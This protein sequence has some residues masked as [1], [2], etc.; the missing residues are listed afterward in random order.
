MLAGKPWKLDS[1]VRLFF[2]LII[3]LCAGAVA[4][5]WW[6]LTEAAGRPSSQFMTMAIL[7]WG[8]LAAALVILHKPWTL[9]SFMPRMVGLLICLS[10]WVVLETLVEKIAKTPPST[11]TVAQIVIGTLSFQGA[12]LIW[13]RRFLREH[14]VGWKEAFG[15]RNHY[16][17]AVFFGLIAGCIFQPVGHEL[18]RLSALLMEHWPRSGL[19]PEEQEAVQALRS[20]VTWADRVAMGVATIGF[21]PV[22]EEM[23]FRGILYPVI[24]QAGFPRLAFWGV[25]LL[26]AAIH[27]NL[28]NFLPL[29]LLAVLFTVLYERTNNLWAP[30]AAHAL[31]NGWNF[32][33]LYL[34]GQ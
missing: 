17:Q 7:A 3:C 8:F 10:G 21:A 19:K 4:S 30:I 28:M 16:L 33:W 15:F 1:T 20:A 31:S 18:Q 23:L 12:G 24:K 11:G 27:T 6:Q 13:I 29:F 34:S 22:A 2:S 26:F 32:A 25:S 9:D 14:E 5:R